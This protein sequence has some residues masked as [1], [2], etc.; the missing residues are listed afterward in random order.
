MTDV[1]ST[2]S[3]KATRFAI[4]ALGLGLTA[5]LGA[6]QARASADEVANVPA[7]TVSA[8]QASVFPSPFPLAS[9][10]RSRSSDDVSEALIR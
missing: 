7:F 4:W 10:S 1:A 2:V 8:G 9:I 3:E 5:V 6:P